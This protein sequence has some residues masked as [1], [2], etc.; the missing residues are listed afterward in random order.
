MEQNDLTTTIEL[1][2]KAVHDLHLLNDHISDILYCGPFWAED[3]SPLDSELSD[4][5]TAL[6]ESLI[7]PLHLADNARREAR[8]LR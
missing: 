2:I 1:V 4:R 8:K 5:L 6:L 7:D 3:D